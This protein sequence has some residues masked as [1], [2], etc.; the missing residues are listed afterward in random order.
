MIGGDKTFTDTHPQYM[1]KNSNTKRMVGPEDSVDEA[2][3]G[4][5]NPQ[6]KKY[7][8]YYLKTLPP[9]LKQ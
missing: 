9:F 8:H 1:Y 5:N 2:F 6:H 7:V 4:D 3:H